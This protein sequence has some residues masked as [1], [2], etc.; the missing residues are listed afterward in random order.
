MLITLI[1]LFN[2]EMKVS[3]YSLFVQKSNHLLNPR[4]TSTAEN[5]GKGSVDGLEL[6]LSVGINTI[7]S[8]KEVFVE[9][10]NISIFSDIEDRCGNFK[11]R[12]V[13]MIDN[14]ITP[15]EAYINRLVELKREGFRF[16]IRKLEVKN[17]Q[18]YEAILNLMDYMFFDHKKINMESGR[19]FFAKMHPAIKLC[20]GNIDTQETFEQIKAQKAYHYYE[21]PFYRI[22]VTK[23]QTE[24]TPLKANY[25]ELINVVNNN[26]FELTEAASVISRDTALAIDLL[27]MVNKIARNSEFTSVQYAAAMLGQRELKRWINTVVATKLYADK[28]NEI[29]RLSL[30]RAKFAENLAPLF[31]MSTRGSELF[32]MG[33]FS[34]LDVILEKPM[35]EALGMVHVSREIEQVL[36]HRD[37]LFSDLF[38]FM[39]NYENANWQEVS[40]QMIIYEIDMKQVYNA[41]INTLQWYSEVF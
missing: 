5:D 20:A 30:L 2:E 27:E 10:N 12:I 29:T 6:L 1:P 14:S 25:I 26:D 35:D 32:L 38:D 23:G 37:G 9:V 7:S 15:D 8:D 39:I 4:V 3:A 33:L 40:R 36:V 21:G 28:P 16:A 22:P 11:K 34:V 19:I 24:V 31:D 41:Y 13:L 17:F 18:K